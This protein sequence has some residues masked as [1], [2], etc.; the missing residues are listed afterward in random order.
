MLQLWINFHRKK[1]EVQEWHRHE[2]SIEL[3]KKARRRCR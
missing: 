2:V 1:A 3:I